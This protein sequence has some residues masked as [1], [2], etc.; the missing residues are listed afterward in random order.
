VTFQAGRPTHED[1]GDAPRLLTWPFVV[2]MLSGFVYFTA[3][4]AML[5]TEPKFVEQELHG[6]GLEVGLAVGAFAVSAVL[7]RPWIG[8]IGDTHGR[9]VLVVGGAIVAGL[10]MA[11]YSVAT[12]VPMLIAF[13]LVTG[14]G[15]AAFF[16]AV[17]IVSQD[18][19]PPDRRGEAASYFSVALYGGLA[20]GP[21]LGEAVLDAR[22]F[23]TVFVVFGLS[24]LV[25]AALGTQVPS[26]VAGD[27]PSVKRGVLHMP[28][29][30]PGIVL[31]LGVVPLTALTAFL[32]LYADETGIGN[33]GT[34]LAVYSV[35]I[36]VVRIAGARLPDLLGWQRASTTALTTATVGI[37][38]IG[39]WASSIA[40]W[41]G[42]ITL[43][44]GMSL[45]FPALLAALVGSTPESDRSFA[46]ATFMLFFDLSIGFGAALVGGVVSLT[47]QQGG[48]VFAGLCALAGLGAQVLLRERIG[49]EPQAA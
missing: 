21:P 31:A 35:L 15:E 25:A 29:V 40:V 3:V 10:S 24:C 42:T 20:A 36:L 37:G 38:L 48:F 9:R 14:V 26:G 4:G 2:T 23:T 22:G 1:E 5:P 8:R 17:V 28:A 16:T 39:V 19:A 27:R 7:S 13:R 33:V 41:L 34:V 12:S 49:A 44:L 18:L 47:S 43:A 32:P 11:L 30:W 46:V 6:N 45:L